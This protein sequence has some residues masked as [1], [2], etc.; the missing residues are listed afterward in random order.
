M[1]EFSEHGPQRVD[2][3]KLAD[4]L[5]LWSAEDSG[6]MEAE[7]T[8]AESTGPAADGPRP[9]DQIRP[10]SG[11]APDGV[12]ADAGRVGPVAKRAE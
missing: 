9:I 7:L 10:T 8:Y 1:T 5:A 2:V 6:S 12:G 4:W 11:E 3:D